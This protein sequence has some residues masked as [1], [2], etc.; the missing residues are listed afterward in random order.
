[1]A[2]GGCA[3]RV[4]T[5]TAVDTARRAVRVRFDDRRDSEDRPLISDWLQVVRRGD[6]L[7]KVNDQA[8][9]LYEGVENGRGYLLGGVT[10]WR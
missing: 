8:L 6:W 5:V 10:A 1:M 9:V 4:G 3:L 2:R 7:P